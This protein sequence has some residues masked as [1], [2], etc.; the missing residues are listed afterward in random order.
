M[1]FDHWGRESN[2]P[3]LPLNVHPKAISRLL[4]SHAF[5]FEDGFVAVVVGELDLDCSVV[6]EFCGSFAFELI[7]FIASGPTE[8]DRV[9]GVF[10]FEAGLPSTEGNFSALRGDRQRRRTAQIEVSAIPNVGLDDPPAAD[11]AAVGRRLHAEAS[12]S[13]GSRARS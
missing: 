13:F 2:A 10:N 8:A 1:N 12:M 5:G 4:R 7:S 6:E 11:Q 9:A 3:D